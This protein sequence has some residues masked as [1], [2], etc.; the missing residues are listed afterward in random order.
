MASCTLKI[1]FL[2]TLNNLFITKAD[3]A[4]GV[5]KNKKKKKLNQLE[6]QRTP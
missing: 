3:A 5:C 1:K 6:K 2:L 4:G